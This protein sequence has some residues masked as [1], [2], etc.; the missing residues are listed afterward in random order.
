V[1]PVDFDADPHEYHAHAGTT[2][3]FLVGNIYTTLGGQLDFSLD[4]ELETNL[5]LVVS[6]PSIDY[7]KSVRV[8]AHFP[9]S[10]D[11]DNK[12]VSIY[13][14]E[15]GGAK[16]LVKRDEVDASGNLSTVVTLTKNTKF[17][18]EWAG[19]AGWLAGASPSKTVGVH[20]ITITKLAGFFATSG[21]YKLYHS[22]DVPRITGTV[23]PNHHGRVL[24]FV[25]EIRRGGA[26]RALS[27]VNFKIGQNGSAVALLVNAA[28]GAYR[29]KNLFVGDA[30]HLGD[31]SDWQY[32]KVI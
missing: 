27:T 3:F 5:G 12:T 17:V 20:V 30:D 21:P 4:G 13:K 7:K 8:T 2:Y 16:T 14:T 23:V 15:Y 24:R 26:W 1:A 32:L 9:D 11:V 25:L 10:A 31:T 22:G 18:A 6:H 28:P 29:V 19:E